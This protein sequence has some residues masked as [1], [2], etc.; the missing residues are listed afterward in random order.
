METGSLEMQEEKGRDQEYIFFPFFPKWTEV[1]SAE[2]SLL[3]YNENPEILD[4]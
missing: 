1:C 3:E 2:N 4:K